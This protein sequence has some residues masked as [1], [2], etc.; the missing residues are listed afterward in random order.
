MRL[1]EVWKL[2]AN[3][4]EPSDDPPA[5]GEDW[6]LE[7]YVDKADREGRVPAEDDHRRRDVLP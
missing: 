5:E 2:F 1:K 7:Q 4:E 3:K 6:P